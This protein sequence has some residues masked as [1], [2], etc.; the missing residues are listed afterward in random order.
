M[1]SIK[2][3]KAQFNSTNKIRND[4]V[5]YQVFQGLYK[6]VIAVRNTMRECNLTVLEIHTEEFIHNPREQMESVCEFLGLSC[7]ESYLTMCE[8]M[9][10]KNV[11]RTR[12]SVE[13]STQIKGL[14]ETRMLQL[15]FF[16]RYSFTD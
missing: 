14:V 10:Y 13:W 4:K 1:S 11:S 5:V 15:P 16:E 3:Q 8:Q 2:R 9:T 6:E 7:S 12:D